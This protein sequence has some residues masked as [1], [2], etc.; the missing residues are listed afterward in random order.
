MLLKSKPK[1]K[2]IA[3]ILLTSF[4][5]ELKQHVTLLRKSFATMAS[6]LHE[7]IQ[8]VEP[9]ALFEKKLCRNHYI[10]TASFL[11]ELIQCVY[12][13]IFFEKS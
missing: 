10:G 5:H 7:L 6:S 1:Y 13:D 3:F 11:H 8:N 9:D 12:S 4:L 2:I